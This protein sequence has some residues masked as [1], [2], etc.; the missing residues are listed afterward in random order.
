[1][2]RYGNCLCTDD[3]P[4]CGWNMPFLTHAEYREAAM[5]RIES[6]VMVSW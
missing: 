5:T 4:M 2:G 3:D 1:M 6:T